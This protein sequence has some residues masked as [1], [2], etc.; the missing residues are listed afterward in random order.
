MTNI[1]KPNSLI[2]HLM[3]MTVR[4]T[5]LSPL[6]LFVATAIPPLAVLAFT[7]FLWRSSGRWPLFTAA[8]IACAWFGGFESGIAATVL[9]TAL[10][11]WFF[12]PPEY[13]I[14][15]SASAPYIAAVVFLCTGILIS[16][17]FRRLHRTATVLVRIQHLLQGIVQHSPNGIAI[18]DVDR[19][20]ILLNEAFEH[21]EG[22]KFE[23]ALR[24][25]A[26]DVLPSHVAEI[27]ADHERQAL[28]KHTPMLFE[29]TLAGRSLLISHFPL[30]DESQHAFAIGEIA[31]DITQQKRDQEALRESL[32]ELRI[33]EH[34]AHVGSWRWDFRTNETTWSDELYEIFG[35][36]RDRSPFPLL[37]PGLRLLTA[38][39]VL[40]LAGAIDSLRKDGASFELDLEFTRPDGSTRWCAARGEA[41]RDPDGRIRGVAATAAD[42]THIKHLERLR[43][44]WTTIIAHDL[45]QPIGVI[46]SA[47]ELIP[48][49][50][51]VR[52]EELGMLERIQSAAGTLKRM[53]E[54]LLDVSLLEAHHLKLERSWVEPVA[55]VHEAANRLRGVTGDRVEITESGPPLN[56]RVD[57]MRIEQVLANLLSNAAKYGDAHAPIQVRVDRAA[58]EVRIAVTN[59]GKGIAADELRR[60]FDRFARSRTTSGSGV[61]GLG[62]GLYITKEIVE[63]HGGHIWAE[64]E[65][66]KTTTFRIA[67]PAA[68]SR[69]E[70]A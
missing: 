33:A 24:R 53:V 19:R 10:M 60:I 31:T 16:D 65:P 13:V 18:K 17:I 34:V 66:G 39:S 45:R 5:R 41:I 58:T 56:L 59:R 37:N 46:S 40:R 47:S 14:F 36:D 12:V 55:L 26:E 6:K 35:I 20:Y 9:S 67:L 61:P 30:L 27:I 22:L 23:D 11:W 69:L 7:F 1:E 2:Q 51:G 68:E 4:Q 28:E 25:R 38:E 70:A 64:S 3:A 15:K 62:L 49:L 63:A 29:T 42:I 54:D 44:E 57:P 48:E 21:L 50:Y 8:V 32:S 43:E 52:G